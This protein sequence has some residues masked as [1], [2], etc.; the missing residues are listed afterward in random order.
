MN[1]TAFGGLFLIVLFGAVLLRGP[2][3]GL[4]PMHHDEANQAVKFG[5]LL[6]KSEYRYDPA[7]HHGPALYYLTLPIARA[8][9]KST[10]ASLEE[11]TLRFLPV[12]FG[13]GIILL[14]L[15][16]VKDMGRPAVLL[17][18]LCAS[19]SPAFSYYSRFY[20][21]EMIF[22]FFCLGFIGSIWRYLKRPGP[23]WA[24]AWGL[25]VGLMYATKETSVIIFAA[26]AGALV[27]TRFTQKKR[28]G[29]P[30]APARMRPAHLILALAAAVVMAAL[31][32]SSFFS[33]PKGIVD[34]VAAFQAYLAKGGAA[35]F[36]AHPWWYYLGL[37]TH[38]SSGG[39]VWSE[40][41]VLAL[42]CF[43]L[44]SAALK[45]DRLTVFLS[46]YAILAL[47]AFSLIPY[48]TPWNLLP[49]YAGF[50][51]L[52]G[53]GAAFV[54][55]RVRQRYLKIPIGLLLVLGFAHL[56]WQS[57][58]AN[59]RYHSD[60][61]NPY[62]YAQ[63]SPDY[64]RLVRRVD[65][66]AALHPDHERLLIKVVCGPYETWP[67]PWSL[68]RYERVGYWTEAPAADGFEDAPIVIASQEIAEKIGPL[69]ADKFQA[70]FYGLRPD[71]LLT[72]YIRNDLWDRFIKNK[73]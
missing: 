47:T 63:T 58:Q 21:Q 37:L 12:L 60:P 19:L 43:G 52:A 5:L 44:L 3:L 17:A 40:A 70:E 2:G 10:L 22:V 65:A 54:F 6:E 9:G 29:G 18:G 66:V 24:I 67:L 33:N 13:V 57:Y 48:K 49:F 1:K 72:L 25:F 16:F 4:R 46:F 14:L 41:L 68:R 28:S 34:S 64:L 62:V 71:V 26:V 7:D 32:F 15:V 20:I 73:Y 36:H 69:L 59:F 30:A 42:A 51:L 45:R 61:R 53:A 11:T 50:I 56:G 23:G 55:E 39:L 35:G 38:V 27:L 8:A 31:F